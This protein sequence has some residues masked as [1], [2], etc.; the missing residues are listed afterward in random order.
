MAF[1]DTGEPEEGGI[2][3]CIFIEGDLVHLRSGGPRM[4]VGCVSDNFLLN[5]HWFDGAIMRE[6]ELPDWC[7]AACDHS[8]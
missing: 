2:P 7:F 5:V 3:K 1:D 8:G 6:T 4:V